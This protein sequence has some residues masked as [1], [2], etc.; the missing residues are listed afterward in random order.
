MNPRVLLFILCLCVCLVLP[1]ACAREKSVWQGFQGAPD[2]GLP[3]YT[4]Q[5][6]TSDIHNGAELGTGTLFVAHGKLRYEMKGSGPLDQMLL[7]ARLDSGQAWL[8]NPSGTRCL[9]G[10]FAPQRWMTVEYLLE[11]FPKVSRPRIVAV[12]EETLGAET[13]SGHKVSKIRRTGRAA[14]FGEEN[15]FT[16][17]FWL[18]EESCIPL[19]HENDMT[20]TELANIHRQDLADSL[21]TL[22][23]EC[24]K[25]SSLV[26]LL[27]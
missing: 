20:R 26:E 24:R 5:L 7:I 19:R 25:V 4:A 17:F 14:M 9:E 15:S 3:A 16:E 6:R 13:L 11:A 22:P 21:F 27:Q 12:N 1:Y 10:G 18:A 23:A 2:R 8:I